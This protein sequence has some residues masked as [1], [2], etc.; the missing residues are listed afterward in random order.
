MKFSTI[1]KFVAKVGVSVA[2]VWWVLHGVDGSALAERFAKVSGGVLAA[3]II[4]F[5]AMVVLQALRWR[6]VLDSLNT[7]ISPRSAI[8]IT[9]LSIFFNQA[10][11]STVGG[12]VARVWNVRSLGISLAIATNSVIIDRVIGLL[13]LTALGTLGV[14]YLLGL[15]DGAA[16]FAMAGLTLAAIAACAALLGLR[17]L[18]QSWT[19]WLIFRGFVSLSRAFWSVL[20]SRRIFSQAFGLSLLV[21]MGVISVMYLLGDSMGV[22]LGL[23]SYLAVMP[24]VLLASSLPISIAG[25]GVRESAMI[26]GL[27]L[28]GVP[29]EAALATSLLFG[30]VILA[31]GL[32]G[33][34]LWL[35]ERR[36]PGTGSR[37]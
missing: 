27:D 18:P 2:L 3:A 29:A 1:A 33:A 31:S 20:L 30:G 36:L 5:L 22:P 24:P 21:H 9:M 26:V 19:K 10:L 14:P 15:A 23:A 6:I 28:L 12:D 16:G 35:L 34:A 37:G 4:G 32:A 7:A 8:S 13:A 17:K 11:P 25:W